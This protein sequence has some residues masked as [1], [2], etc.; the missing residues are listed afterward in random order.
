LPAFFFLRKTVKFWY[1]LVCFFLWKTV[2]FSCQVCSIHSMQEFL[3]F[4]GIGR[5]FIF[6]FLPVLWSFRCFF[7]KSSYLSLNFN[8]QV[9]FLIFFTEETTDTILF[10]FNSSYQ[11]LHSMVSRSSKSCSWNSTNKLAK[12]TGLRS[13]N[14]LIILIFNLGL[15]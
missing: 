5:S 14:L 7:W 1:V 11:L 12:L 8:F 10:I 15:H 13:L 4:I 2:Q 3:F 9:F 6:Y